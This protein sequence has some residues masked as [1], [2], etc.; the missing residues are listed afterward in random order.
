MTQKLGI[1]TRRVG[2]IPAQPCTSSC[3]TTFRRSGLELRLIGLLRRMDGIPARQSAFNILGL[4]L[5]FI[6]FLKDG[7]NRRKWQRK[8]KTA[9]TMDIY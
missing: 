4:S 2:N 3:Y 1:M 7:Q 8:R 9:I 6:A 5:G